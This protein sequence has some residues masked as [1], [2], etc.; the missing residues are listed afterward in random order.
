MGYVKATSVLPQEIIMLIQE[1]I[2]G[3]TLYIPKKE[4][5]KKA[6]GANT[7]TKTILK[8]RNKNIYEDYTEGME[9]QEI[10]EKYHLSIKSIYRILAKQK[11]L[12]PHTSQ[13]ASLSS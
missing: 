8:D 10:A 2:E 3:E 1:Y 6:W 4:E 7:E 13:Y 9:A 12:H 5:T 11:T